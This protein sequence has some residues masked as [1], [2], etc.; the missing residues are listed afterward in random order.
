[1][2]ES[3]HWVDRVITAVIVNQKKKE[4]NQTESREAN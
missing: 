2:T 4:E 1:M 3:D